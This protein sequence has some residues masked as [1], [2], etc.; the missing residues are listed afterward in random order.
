MEFMSI[1][2]TQLLTM[3]IY[4]AVGFFLYRASFVTR[5]GC[6]ELGSLL[7]YI[8]LPAA[9]LNSYCV[10][11]T[12]EK[13]SDLA[14]SMAAAFFA[15]LLSMLISALL[16]PREKIERF[17]IAFSNAG[18][19]GIPIVSAVLGSEAVFYVS[20]FVALLNIFQW[21]YGVAIMT[22]SLDCIQIRKLAKNPILISMAGGLILFFTQLPLP[23]VVTQSLSSLAGLNAPMAMI[24]LGIYLAQTDLKRIFIQRRFYWA[25]AVRLL[26][27]PA[28]TGLFLMVFPTQPSIRLAVLIAASAPIGSNVAIFAQLHHLDY[29]K[30][31]SEVCLSTILSII[32]MPAVL[33]GFSAL[34]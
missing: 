16:F 21:T 9:I 12:P 31:V 33:A 2:M 18:F 23:D 26:I 10:E 30:A 28:V 15:L 11:R 13:I 34:I 17:G 25:S 29:T 4:M 19:M 6:K 7:L 27:I 1:L 24:I 14:F 8:I 5:Q 3:A 22:D 20:S 32:T